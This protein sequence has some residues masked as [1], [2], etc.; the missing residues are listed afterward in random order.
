MKKWFILF[1]MMVFIATLTLS[2]D[3][4]KKITAYG[5]VKFDATYETGSSYP[6]NYVFWAQDPGL[7]DGLFHLTANQTRVG[8]NIQGFGFGKFKVT[9]KVEIDFYGGNAE[10]KAYNFMRKAYLKISNG[11][12]SILAGQN[13]DVMSPLV[14]STLNY[15][16]L[17]GAGNIGYR[18]PQLT[19]Q[20][21]FKLGN[22]TF[23]LQYGVVRSIATGINGGVALGTPT[24]QGR[25][26]GKFLFG[27]SSL[28]LGISGHTGKYLDSDGEDVTTQS[29]NLD[30]TLTLS[31]KLKLVGEY[32]TGKNLG[33]YLGGILQTVNELGDEIE[34]TG[35]FVNLVA[36][37]WKNAQLS[38][39]YGMDDPNDDQLFDENRSKNTAVFGNL[40]VNL[41]KSL[42]VG[43]EISQ[44]DTDY[45]NADSQNTLRIQ[46][47]WILAL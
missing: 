6:G 4:G 35:F 42:K 9:G 3:E 47:S 10:N 45:L 27:K 16:V 26:A 34:A 38:I 5:F 41:S 25:A 46:N 22:H 30:C 14:A 21:D 20:N 15:T 18:R 11:S 12:F 33:K 31:P 40:V 23:T 32:F 8:I 36:K 37:P 13:S 2:A 44:W 24:L 7:S 17:W 29:V 28:Q 43:L 1:L 19:F 39:G